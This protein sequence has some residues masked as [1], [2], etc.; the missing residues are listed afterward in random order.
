MGNGKMADIRAA[1]KWFKIEADSIHTCDKG[2]CDYGWF[3]KID[4]KGPFFVTSK[5]N[6]CCP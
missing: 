3:R 2:Y 1:R 5:V 6:C 4:G